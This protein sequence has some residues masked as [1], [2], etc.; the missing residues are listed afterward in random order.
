MNGCVENA[1]RRR[2]KAVP[3]LVS[4]HSQGGGR[5]RFIFLEASPEKATQDGGTFNVLAEDNLPR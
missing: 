4:L 5:G 3:W 2:V 1:G